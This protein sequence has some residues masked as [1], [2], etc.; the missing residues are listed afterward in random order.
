MSWTHNSLVAQWLEHTVQFQVVWG[1]IPC[2]AFLPVT[3]Y[4]GLAIVSTMW[5]YTCVQYWAKFIHLFNTQVILCQVSSQC[6]CSKTLRVPNARY[7][8][9]SSGFK[10]RMV[11]FLVEYNCLTTG[12]NIQRKC[13]SLKANTCKTWYKSNVNIS[14]MHVYLQVNTCWKEIKKDK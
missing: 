9:R 3:K 13:V 2:K 8:L 12:L 14:E 10:L 11:E 1:L 7:C 5:V 6:S 4:L